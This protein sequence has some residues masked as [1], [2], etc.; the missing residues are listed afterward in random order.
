M[1][2][3]ITKEQEERLLLYATYTI[4]YLNDTACFS[5]Q[6]LG[7]SVKERDK[8]SQKIYGALL[9][10]NKHYLDAINKIVD[11]KMDYYCDYCTEMDN[12]CDDAYSEFKASLH[13][14]YSDANIDDCQY[15]A[16][17]E[18]MRSMVELSVEAGK[19]VIDSVSTATPRAKWLG[20]YL[21]ADMIRVANN[22]A[23]WSYRKVPKGIKVDLSIDS[24][25]MN[26]FKDLSGKLIDYESFITAY[27]RAIELEV[28][29]EKDKE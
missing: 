2:N 12:I 13:N 3:E 26:K 1:K 20:N 4:L 15:M 16:Q 29:R 11:N 23:N 5:I 10:R 28:E 22:F 14:A 7:K 24:D 21:L 18:T 19:K 6:Q 8:E 25:V 9:K 17:V 27:K